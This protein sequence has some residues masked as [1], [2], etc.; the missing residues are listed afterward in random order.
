MLAHWKKSYDKSRQHI[1]RQKHYFANKGP[2]SQSYGLYSSHIWVWEL[3]N[4]KSWALRTD[5]CELWYWRRL[6]RVPW[7]ARISNQSTIKKKKSV[8]DIHWKDWYWSWCS[9]TL[10]TWCE[11]LSHWKRLWFWERLNA[12]GKE[13]NRRLDGWQASMTW[14]T[15]VWTSFGSWWWTGNSGML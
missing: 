7:T 8:L 11:E 4:K 14:W 15:W 3:D 13:D 6:F 10:A 12:G 5:V 1:K 9:S 2:S